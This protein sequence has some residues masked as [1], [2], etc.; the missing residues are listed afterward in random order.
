MSNLQFGTLRYIHQHQV[1]I[2]DLNGYNLSTFG[3]LAKR[4]WVTRKG[5][6]ILCTK[7]G[8]EAFQQ[9]HYAS[10][11]YRQH[12]GEISERVR[13]LLHIGQLRSMKAPAP[14]ISPWSKAS[15]VQPVA[16]AGTVRQYLAEG[17]TA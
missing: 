7:K 4:G 10:C 14:V 12:A 3:S 17:K 2:E 15:A 11:N 13:L 6:R 8:E 16:A 1:S 9:Y 5:H